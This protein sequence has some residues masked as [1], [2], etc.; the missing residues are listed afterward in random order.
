MVSD[1]EIRAFE[2][3]QPEDGLWYGV[4]VLEGA[5]GVG[6]GR[7]PLGS[8]HEA[9]QHERNFRTT[10]AQLRAKNM[11]DVDIAKHLQLRSTS[12]L[13]SRLSKSKE[14][15]HAYEVAFAKRLK[16]KGMSNVAIATRMFKDPGK[17]STVRNLLK[18]GNGRKD[19]LY[20]ELSDEL[21]KEIEK[22]PYLDVGKGT[23][24]YLGAEL[25][26][27]VTETR[28]KNVLNGL[29]REGYKVHPYIQVE[30]YGKE[31]A[32]QKT[33][34]KVL[35]KGDVT[36]REVYQHLSEIKPAGIYFDDDADA[37]KTFE[38][39]K[40]IDPSRVYIR[41]AE[42]VGADGAK[43]IDKDGVIELRR[44]V[45]DLSLGKA[46][47]AQVRI[48]VGGTHY[49][50]GMALYS[51]TIPEGYDVVFNT[52][53]HAG[54]PMMQGKEGVLKPLKTLKDGTI[55]ITNPFGAAIKT[56]DQLFLSR[57]SDG[58]LRRQR[59]YIDKDGKEQLSA[60]NIVNEEGDWKKWS[61]EISSQML[62]KQPW[63]IA[64][65]QLDLTY[66]MK[67]E[68]LND[69]LSLTNPT[70]KRRLLEQF[71][72]KCDSDA[73]DL[74]AYG[75]PGQKHK[76][77]LPVTTLKDNECYCPE[78]D[79]GTNVVLIRHPHAGIFEIPFLTVNNNHPDGKKILGP[80]TLDAI[81]IPKAAF[82]QLS[83]ADADGDTAIVIPVKS[84]T[85]IIFDKARKELLDF[86][87]KEAYR[88]Y[89]GMKKMTPAMKQKQMGIV[90][91][92]IT[93]MTVAGAPFTDMV[94]AVKHSMVVIDAEKHN[95]DWR[96]SEKENDIEDL[97]RRYQAHADGTYGG[98]STLISQA[99][100]TTYMNQMRFKG[101]DKKTGQK[102]YEPTNKLT[103][104]TEQKLK[105]A[106]ASKFGEEAANNFNR[107]DFLT[108]ED[109]I[110]KFARDYA[111]AKGLYKTQTSTRMADTD[112]ARTLI[113]K[114]NKPVEH[115][116]ANYANQ[117]KAMALEARKAMVDTPRLERDPEARKI[118]APEVASL[119]AKLHD[120]LRNK[121]LER[122]ALILA[123]VKVKQDIFNDPSLKENK[124]DLKKL[125]GRTLQRMRE[126]TGANKHRVF[127]TDNE[128]KA[129][130][131]GAVSDS[132]LSRLLENSDD[133]HVKQLAMPKE[134]ITIGS[135]KG[136]MIRSLVGRY[137]YSEIAK[138]LD[139]SVSTVQDIALGMR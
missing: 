31:D 60:V 47:Y 95:L 132:F 133:N 32:T 5:P 111:D 128:W 99:G 16:E 20:K 10:V 134:K 108:K 138:M 112:D 17:E 73:V 40:S 53:K 11:S 46:H 96:R 23:E 101:Y 57:E 93:D 123:N 122:Q 65:R 54:T 94:K 58:A 39:P 83:G 88:G 51:D 71:A 74:K 90:S 6:S 38:M 29:E 107:K 135:A 130:Q 116:Y 36:D 3:P 12:E 137:S 84:D 72:D 105:A 2:T 48:A 19:R 104:K 59:H 55:D 61:H 44:G 78:F 9:Y 34:I 124:A 22:H 43:G 37:Y 100:S 14:E 118:F 110:Y 13:R 86:E 121:P 126:R 117:M 33:S 125:K 30:Q 131:A 120:A 79:N 63:A 62:S 42:D 41:Y 114:Y 21:K 106:I 52:N 103:W 56:E 81:G 64:K 27:G 67:R 98:A 8:G 85:G 26:S 76:V 136:N 35:T 15:I 28:L 113:S 50:K 127:F 139:V 97:K 119:T 68:Q 69:I 82:N 129:I 91:N 49:L 87:P 24:L 25:Q 66:E 1:I 75:F 102:M 77:L 115:V 109:D 7:Y 70:V 4:S 80:D 45:E 18:E 89:P 92:L